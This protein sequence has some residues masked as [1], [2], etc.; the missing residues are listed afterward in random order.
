MSRI[1]LVLR[2]C[3]SVKFESCQGFDSNP[4]LEYLL[5]LGTNASSTV[6]SL[7]IIHAR[8]CLT[9]LRIAVPDNA[10]QSEAL[11]LTAL[12][13]FF[14]NNQCLLSPEVFQAAVGIPWTGAIS[15]AQ[16]K[17][18]PP[19]PPLRIKTINCFEVFFFIILIFSC[20]RE[21]VRSKG[22]AFSSKPRVIHPFVLRQQP[23]DG[24]PLSREEEGHHRRC[25]EKN[26][27]IDRRGP[28]EGKT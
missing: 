11:Y 14:E 12:T 19:L 8:L 27:G 13:Q 10:E 9:A 7:G 23:A 21:I 17:Y 28:R 5:N 22:T 18:P 6:V 16:G 24:D 25:N 2:K 26:P 3:S 15:L 1:K 20:C 4:V